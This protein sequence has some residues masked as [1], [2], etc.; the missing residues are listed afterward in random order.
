MACFV[1]KRPAVSWLKLRIRS[2]H[3]PSTLVVICFFILRSLEGAVSLCSRQTYVLLTLAKFKKHHRLKCAKDFFHLKKPLGL[4]RISS[5]WKHWFLLEKKNCFFNIFKYIFNWIVLNHFSYKQQ[6][7][8]LF[9]EECEG[10]AKLITELNQD[11]ANTSPAEVLQVQ[12]K[13]IVK[14]TSCL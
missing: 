4:R 5:Y 7:F 9:R 11:L 1:T 12:S 6:K 8:N 10:Y 2:R 14:S 13:T 3:L